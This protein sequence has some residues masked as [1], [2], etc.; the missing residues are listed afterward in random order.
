VE[1]VDEAP[2]IDGTAAARRPTSSL[3]VGIAYLL[4]TVGVPASDGPN[5][6]EEF[7]RVY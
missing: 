5:A 4:N 2:S 6:D 1:D 7:V 3:G